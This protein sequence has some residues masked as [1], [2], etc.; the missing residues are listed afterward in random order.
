VKTNN[1]RG[2][3]FVNSLVTNVSYDEN[4]VETGKNG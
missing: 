1:V 4:C 3:C 2:Y